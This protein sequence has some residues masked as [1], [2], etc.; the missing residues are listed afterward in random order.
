MSAATCATVPT[1]STLPRRRSPFGSPAV[2]SPTSVSWRSSST[3]KRFQRSLHHLHFSIKITN[4]LEKKWP[5]TVAAWLWIKP[6][7]VLV[8]SIGFLWHGWLSNIIEREGAE[9]ET[10]RTRL[11][12]PQILDGG[13]VNWHVDTLGLQLP[14]SH[15]DPLFGYYCKS[16]GKRCSKEPHWK[17]ESI[18]KHFCR[19]RLNILL[20]LSGSRTFLASSV[21]GSPFSIVSRLKKWTLSWANIDYYHGPRPKLNSESTL[22][23]N[24]SNFFFGRWNVLLSK[25]KTKIKFIIY[26]SV[27]ASLGLAQVGRG[28]TYGNETSRQALPKKASRESPAWAP[29]S[30]KSCRGFGFEWNQ[31]LKDFVKVSRKKKA[32]MAMA[33]YMPFLQR[34]MMK[35]AAKKGWMNAFYF[36]LSFVIQD[37]IGPCTL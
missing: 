11:L 5:F 4:E 14:C 32:G 9:K 24:I 29:R 22:K 35:W 17:V 28:W 31:P 26:T 8:E 27:P 6:S 36:L 34:V 19:G 33:R 7:F 18:Q 23:R 25:K 2:L 12:S 30:I 21:L 20:G 10:R 16:L 15:M 3:S 1:L 37:Q 13:R